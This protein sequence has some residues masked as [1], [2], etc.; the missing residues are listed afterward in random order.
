MKTLT[1]TVLQC[2]L[3]VLIF[4]CSNTDEPINEVLPKNLNNVDL[5]LY[6]RSHTKEVQ[7]ISLQELSEVKINTQRQV[8]RVLSSERRYSLWK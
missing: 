7:K 3:F 6:I 4:S 8:H 1:R 2:S 5:A